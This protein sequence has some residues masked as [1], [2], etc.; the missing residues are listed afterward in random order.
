MKTLLFVVAILTVVAFLN[1]EQ[2]GNEKQMKLDQPKQIL[3]EKQK[4]YSARE[5]TYIALIN[6]GPDGYKIVGD[7]LAKGDVQAALLVRI[8]GAICRHDLVWQ[9]GADLGSNA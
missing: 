4:S 1:A 2:G 3:S 9:S 6:A 8:E 7:L 5:D